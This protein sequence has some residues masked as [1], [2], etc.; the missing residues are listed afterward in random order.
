MPIVQINHTAP[1]SMCDDPIDHHHVS[2]PHALDD[3]AV[4]QSSPQTS[5]S[6]DV[7]LGHSDATHAVQDPSNSPNDRGHDILCSRPTSGNEHGYGTASAAGAAGSSSGPTFSTSSH[8]HHRLPHPRDVLNQRHHH[9]HTLTGHNAPSSSAAGRR[10]VLDHH[11]HAGHNIGHGILRRHPHPRS[12]SQQHPLTHSRLHVHMQSGMHLRILGHGHRHPAAPV[13]SNGPQGHGQPRRLSMPPS[14]HSRARQGGRLGDGAVQSQ[15]GTEYLDNVR[16]RFSSLP[17]VHPPPPRFSHG[18]VYR[19]HAHGSF[20][21]SRHSLH[22]I[23]SCSAEG[24]ASV[25]DGEHGDTSAPP[26]S[27]SPTPSSSPPPVPPDSPPGR[28]KTSTSVAHFGPELRTELRTMYHEDFPAGHSV[29]QDETVQQALPGL[30]CHPVVSAGSGCGGAVS[31]P[32][33]VIAGELPGPGSGNNSVAPRRSGSGPTPSANVSGA[34]SSSPVPGSGSVPGH[35]A[36]SHLPQA[37]SLAPAPPT[38][39]PPAHVSVSA[40]TP[41]RKRR[42]S[43]TPAPISPRERDTTPTMTMASLRPRVPL[44]PPNTLY[45]RFNQLTHETLEGE[46]SCLALKDVVALTR[47]DAD[48]KARVKAWKESSGDVPEGFSVLGSSLEEVLLYA[49]KPVEIG[50]HT[51]DLPILV[52]ACVE[53]LNRTGIYQPL[54]FRALP[55]RSQHTLLLSVYDSSVDFGLHFTPRGQAMPGLCALLASFASALPEP[56]LPRAVYGPLWE[57]AVTPSVYEAERKAA[58]EEDEERGRPQPRRPYSFPMMPKQITAQSSPERERIRAEKER[59]GRALRE[60]AERE[61][62]RIAQVL[63]RMAPRGQASLLAYLCGFFAQV[64][65]A[66]ENGMSFEDVARIFAVPM[67]GG[68]KKGPNEAG[69]ARG[70]A[71]GGEVTGTHGGENGDLQ[72]DASQGMT[73]RE[74]SEYM[75]VWLL[76]RWSRISDGLFDETCGLDPSLSGP[77]PSSSLEGSGLKGKVGQKIRPKSGDFVT[78]T[79]IIKGREELVANH[80]RKPSD[81]DL[82]LARACGYELELTRDTFEDIEPPASAA[83]A[84]L[85]Q[86]LPQKHN[87]PPAPTYD[88]VS[89]PTRRSLPSGSLPASRRPSI[90]DLGQRARR[91]SFPEE[92]QAL[93]PSF[94]PGMRCGCPWHQQHPPSPMSVCP[95][96]N[97]GYGPPPPLY[98]NWYPHPSEPNMDMPPPP[99]PIPPPPQ[100]SYFMRRDFVAPYPFRP[101]MRP[102]GAL[103]SPMDVDVTPL[104]V[105]VDVA[106]PL[107]NVDPNNPLGLEVEHDRDGAGSPAAVALAGTDH[108]LQFSPSDSEPQQYPSQSPRARREKRGMDRSTHSDTEESGGRR[109]K[110]YAR[111]PHVKN[112]SLSTSNPFASGFD[113]QD[114]LH[115]HGRESRSSRGAGFKVSSS[116]SSNGIPTTGASGRKSVRA[117]S[118]SPTPYVHVDVPHS[119][120]TTS[121]SSLALNSP[122][123][124]PPKQ[125][126]TSP[127]MDVRTW[128]QDQSSP[129]SSASTSSSYV[130][131]KPEEHQDGGSDAPSATSSSP[132]VAGSANLLVE[133]HVRIEQLERA[134]ARV[135]SGEGDGFKGRNKSE[136]DDTERLRVELQIVKAERDKAQ[137][138]VREMQRVVAVDTA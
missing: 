130:L 59:K 47:Q 120:A 37:Q 64:E 95:S 91:P 50:E 46:G 44:L 49:S 72:A 85:L 125:P 70:F 98:A 75:L 135:S 80:I 106:R 23:E 36:R 51:H 107:T 82:R 12:P 22:T 25:G 96:P 103:S 117:L 43:L 115:S 54:L 11:H 111:S 112:A 102:D 121:F 67:L 90:P 84:S 119:A 63:L 129:P 136:W 17:G 94:T 1:H 3:I 61:Q 101:P 66:P 40:P 76:E 97:L 33:P 57:R 4:S 92:C 124:S 132:A 131:T 10:A 128:L 32:P 5:P 45:H 14:F 137:G 118:L 134:L 39:P 38:A 113:T 35:P 74:Q 24:D 69:S 133:A 13:S 15:E 116:G 41:V 122:P 81:H 7:R 105:K 28:A 88:Q 6:L 114:S 20:D 138:V 21:F 71:N 31:G 79:K 58:E 34:P 30:L 16:G 89:G 99:D 73:S 62:V 56:L 86:G 83:R 78:G 77:S 19:N 65:F 18:G 104:P 68:G 93:R 27:L 110:P 60:A 26:K 55:S 53:E 100:T 8:S 29:E 42:D 52:V 108:R 127:F 9:G 126:L 2:Q 48:I 123:N 87:Q 109:T